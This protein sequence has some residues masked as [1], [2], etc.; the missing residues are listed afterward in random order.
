M[1]NAHIAAANGQGEAV[2][3]GF[4][5]D[6]D[7]MSRNKSGEY[8][9]F[10]FEYFQKITKYAGWKYEV[11]DGKSWENTLK[12][13]ERGEIDILP[14]VY[15]NDERA[16]R[17]LFSQ[18]P[19]C[20]IYSTLNV[21]V[22]DMR[23]DYEDFSSFNGMRVGVIKDGLDAEYFKEY[24]RKNGFSVTIVP[25]GETADLLSALDRGE[26]DGVAISHLGKNS[27]FRSV[28]QFAPQPLYFA[29]AKDRER[30]ARTLDEAM[31]TIKLRD[32]YYEQ[33]LF[34]KYFAVNALQ[35]PVFTR[36]EMDYIPKAPALRA[37]Y[38]YTEAP[39]EYTDPKT[40]EFKGI[41]ADMFRVIAAYSG[42]TFEF[43]PVHNRNESWNMVDG[44]SADIICGV[45]NDYL[46]AERKHVNTT[47]YYL[48]APFV[49][50]SVSGVS[51]RKRIALPEGCYFSQKIA[52]DNPQAEVVYYPSISDC[53]DAVAKK[54]ADVT[55]TNT[56]VANYLLSERKYE[57]FNMAVLSNYYDDLSIGVSKSTDPR[58]FSIL[59]K[60]I[61][62]IS[63]EQ[64]DSI[65]LDNSVISRP[66]TLR[67]IVSEYPLAAAGVTSV[68]FLVIIG[69]LGYIAVTNAANNRRFH[70]LLYVDGVTG[71]FNLNKFRLDAEKMLKEAGDDPLALV[72]MDINQFKTI[73][74]SFGFKEGDEILKLA[75][76]TLKENTSHDEC[77]ARVSADQFVLLL[78]YSDWDGL[79]SRTNLIAKQMGAAVA[80]MKK[81]YSICLTFGVY[82][83]QRGDSPDVSLLMDF[84]NYARINGK[85]TGKSV[86]LRYDEK[87]R[88]EELRRRHLAD[89]MAPALQNGEF[90]PYFQQKTD[91]RT[92]ETVGAEALVRWL[93]RDEGP[94]SPGDFIPFF[95]SNGFIIE[96]DLYIYEQVCK[97]I[98][99]WMDRGVRLFPVSSNFS[100]LHF[101]DRNFPYTLAEIADRYGV[102]HEYLEVEITENILME[103]VGQMLSHRDLLKKLGFLLSI[104]DFG[105]GYSS[106]SVLQ[107]L[108]AD[109]IKLDRSLISD[110]C[111]ERRGRIIVQGIISMAK[112]LGIDVICEGVETKEQAEML[113]GMGC[114]AAQGFYYAKPMPLDDFEKKFL[115]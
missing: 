25:Y 41:V 49:S 68:V 20:S 23:Y 66:V 94:I 70:A 47:V 50:V 78:H 5:E 10:N 73:N 106:L 90:V 28:A 93:R 30:L 64:M 82:V 104:D 60:C 29:V 3:I 57:N 40:G 51:V 92:G 12:M 108:S 1:L 107:Q 38:N 55:Y 100:R 4:Y 86:T 11:V 88:Q 80:A 76:R 43:L 84:A 22:D 2:K 21:R 109:T 72:Y 13:L 42:L 101:E 58:V 62:Y 111:H 115:P 53:F 110:S 65:I 67:R 46:W 45:A 15:Y 102:P 32:P 59:D 39:L 81:S 103:N 112:E 99:R 37:V 91:M 44:G 52:E 16:K 85:N 114:I 98:R 89:I 34:E 69:V 31:T 95:E 75:A 63:R 33:R 7:Y 48:R 77:C 79:L 14:A 27:V 9:G 35:R 56:Y 96:I 87:M 54:R 8:V 17:F 36:E 105:S 97:T 83:T 24:C 18:R 71:I 26:L 61:Q 19:M 74:D 6:G 113:I